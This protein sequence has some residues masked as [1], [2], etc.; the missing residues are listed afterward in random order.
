MIGISSLRFERSGRELFLEG[1]K[2]PI[3]DYDAATPHGASTIHRYHTNFVARELPKQSIETC[4]SGGRK[5][6]LPGGLSPD[7]WLTL[8]R[9]R[10]A[11]LQTEF[12]IR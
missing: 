9:T 7:D 11:S 4:D 2:R 12:Q 1:W 10:N 3:T 5:A 6:H 8:R